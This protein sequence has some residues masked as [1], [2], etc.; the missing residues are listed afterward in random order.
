MQKQQRVAELQQQKAAMFQQQNDAYCTLD[1]LHKQ[2]TAQ[3]NL[4][5][6]LL[7]DSPPALQEMRE[8]TALHAPPELQGPVLQAML[9]GI[10]ARQQELQQVGRAAAPAAAGGARA[11]VHLQRSVA[12]AAAAADGS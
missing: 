10:E 11:S 3:Y 5:L 6:S 7:R 9:S 1:P 4:G 8:R 12:R 2:L